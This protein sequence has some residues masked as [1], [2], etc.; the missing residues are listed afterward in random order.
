ME[1]KNFFPGT[2]F[3]TFFIRNQRSDSYYLIGKSVLDYFNLRTHTPQLPEIQAIHRLSDQIPDGL[4]LP[5]NILHFR[6][7]IL[8][9]RAKNLKF[10]SGSV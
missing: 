5:K 9:W 3:L 10:L 4:T 1:K 6:S 2:L 7:G 8:K